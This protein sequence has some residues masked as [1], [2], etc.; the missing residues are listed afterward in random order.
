MVFKG[1]KEMRCYKDLS[2]ECEPRK[3]N[4]NCYIKDKRKGILKVF[5]SDNPYNRQNRVNEIAL[6]I[7]QELSDEILNNVV[8]LVY[9]KTKSYPNMEAIRIIRDRIKGVKEL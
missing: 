5:K 7:Y 8:E 9:E 3:C 1:D 2:V 4:K 6:E